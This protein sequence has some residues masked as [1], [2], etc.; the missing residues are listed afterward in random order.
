[1]VGGLFGK[2]VRKSNF[3]EE[4]LDLSC[5]YIGVLVESGKRVDEEI[6]IQS[7][8]DQ[9]PVSVMEDVGFWVPA[10]MKI[11]K[12]QPVQ[13]V[14][15]DEESERC[16]E[17]EGDNNENPTDM[18]E[19]DKDADCSFVSGSQFPFD[20]VKNSEDEDSVRISKITK[21]KK[22]D[23]WVSLGQPVDYKSS[24]SDGLKKGKRARNKD[25][26]GLNELLGLD[27]EDDALVSDQVAD[28]H[29]SVLFADLECR[30]NNVEQGEDSLDL[31]QQPGNATEK[32]PII[33]EN[34][35][36][37]HEGA[38]F[39]NDVE[40]EVVATIVLGE[41]LGARLSNFKDM[42][43]DSIAQEGVQLGNL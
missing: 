12:T 18:E 1:M 11:V 27:E 2:V 10:F 30:T 17:T 14:N 19:K 9:L 4:D 26:F 13:E 40:P 32:G 34:Q 38:T 6:Y 22:Y 7:Q 25:P 3:S 42:V 36:H 20:Q 23:K 5:D 28:G 43:K 21:R 41:T 15:S 37:P 33:T 8:G 31:N 29:D 39:A 35:T 24:G 16:S